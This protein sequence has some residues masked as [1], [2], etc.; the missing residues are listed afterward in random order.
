MVPKHLYQYEKWLPLILI[1]EGNNPNFNLSTYRI[2][3]SKDP[4]N[5]HLLYNI[6]S[7]SIFLHKLETKITQMINSDL[8]L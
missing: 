8:N 5:T 6:N 4:C 3:N 7:G 1:I 2:H